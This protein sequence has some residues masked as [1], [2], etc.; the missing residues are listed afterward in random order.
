MALDAASGIVAEDGLRGLSTRRIANEIGYAAGTLYQLFEDLDDL[1]TQ[2]NA[3]TLEALFEACGGVDYEAGPEAA[4][5]Q[6]ATRYIGFVGENPKLWNALFE[7]TRPDGRNLPER[8]ISAVTNLL[9]LVETA[10][11]PLFPPGKEDRR[12]HEARV[13]WASLYGIT[14]LAVSRKLPD[15]VTPEDMAAS[16]VANYIDGLRSQCAA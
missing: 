13:L 10:L 16:L 4:L 9:G 15:A 1:I 3:G 2:M 14:S 12:L 6:L 7:H 11:A 8:H 5:Q